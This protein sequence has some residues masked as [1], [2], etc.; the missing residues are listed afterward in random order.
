MQKEDEDEEDSGDDEDVKPLFCRS[1][2]RVRRSLKKR[3]HEVT[4]MPFRSWCQR[5]SKPERQTVR[6]R[7]KWT[8]SIGILKFI[9]TIAS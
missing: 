1:H 6:T 4:H 2:Q 7:Y 3:E 5:V 9:L 8:K